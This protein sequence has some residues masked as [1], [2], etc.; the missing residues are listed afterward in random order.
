MLLI[1]NRVRLR[2]F[3]AEQS[4]GRPKVYVS[5]LRNVSVAGIN[6][7]QLFLVTLSSVVPT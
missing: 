3:D 5:R 2:V 6:S 1:L 7:L 4:N